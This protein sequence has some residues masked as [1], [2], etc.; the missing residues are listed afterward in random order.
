MISEISKALLTLQQVKGVGTKTIL[1]VLCEVQNLLGLPE[2]IKNT[3]IRKTLIQKTVDDWTES[4]KKAD[5][6]IEYCTDNHI[7][8]ISIKDST[9]P[10]SLRTIPDP[11]I[12][13]YCIGNTEILKSKGVAIIGTRNSTEIGNK[14]AQKIA[15]TFCENNYNIVS[16]LAEG[17]DTQAHLASLRENTPTVAV[18]ASLGTIFPPSNIELSKKIVQNGGLLLAEHSP[19]KSIHKTDFVTRDR[20]QAA[21][22]DAVIPIEGGVKSGTRHAVEAAFKY[23]KKVIIPDIDKLIEKGYYKG[24]EN[25][26]GLLK[27]LAENPTVAKYSDENVSQ[28]IEDLNNQS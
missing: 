23:G 9:Y 2:A 16:G 24:S 19:L 27:D 12:I 28:I 7:E 8:I 6:T 13:I 25:N 21:L 17:I 1:K 4:T 10:D 20:L 18:L 15:K 5:Q 22:S 11:P 14:V 26:L 3:S